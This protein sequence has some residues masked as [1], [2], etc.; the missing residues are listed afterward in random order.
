MKD[1]EMKKPKKDLRQKFL[2]KHANT[3]NDS[4]PDSKRTQNK[5]D[6]ADAL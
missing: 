5:T 4:D 2:A 6:S 3:G 1:Y